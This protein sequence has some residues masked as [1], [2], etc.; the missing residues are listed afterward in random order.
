MPQKKAETKTIIGMNNFVA[1][2][3]GHV[4]KLKKNN[5]E[6]KVSLEYLKEKMG[7]ELCSGNTSRHVR[8]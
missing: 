7:W 5:N 4:R 8:F 3:K 2:R 6:K 1:K